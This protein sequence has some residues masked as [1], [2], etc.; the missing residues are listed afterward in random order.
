MEAHGDFFHAFYPAVHCYQVQL[1][2]VS[3]L[4]KGLS[5]PDPCFAIVPLLMS[6]YV[7]YFFFY[8]SS[9][10]ISDYPSIIW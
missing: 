7:V 3:S 1:L 4:D 2:L 5:K 9:S 10:A 6:P 8:V